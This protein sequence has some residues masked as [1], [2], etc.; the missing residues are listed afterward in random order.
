MYKVFIKKTLHLITNLK[1][2]KKYIYKIIC[3]KT[4]TTKKH[5]NL[6]LNYRKKKKTKT[7]YNSCYFPL[8]N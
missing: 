7:K 5:C 6:I 8:F 3:K 4:A 2:K 1:R